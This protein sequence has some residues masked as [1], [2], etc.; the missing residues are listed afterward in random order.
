[1]GLDFVPG[2]GDGGR[3]GDLRDGA[4]FLGGERGWLRAHRSAADGFTLDFLGRRA[5]LGRGWRRRSG[6][7]REGGGSLSLELRELAAEVDLEAA[8]AELGDGADEVGDRAS[9]DEDDGD[10]GH[11][12]GK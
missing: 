10:R 3:R 8:V 6:G 7:R 1:L 9:E 5:G 11:G 12:P 4:D 2:E